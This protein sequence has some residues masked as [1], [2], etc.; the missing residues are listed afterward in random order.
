MREE[1]EYGPVVLGDKLPVLLV[2]IVRGRRIEVHNIDKVLRHRA[3]RVSRVHHDNQVEL[4]NVEEVQ[5]AS[6]LVLGHVRAQHKRTYRK[7]GQKVLDAIS[8]NNIVHED[9][10]LP[11]DDRQ[12]YKVEEDEE[13]VEHCGDESVQVMSLL[14]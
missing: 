4:P 7:L 13:F 8:L 1:S 2:A 3:F 10:S 14:E 6:D 5:Y 11:L 9:S 12:F